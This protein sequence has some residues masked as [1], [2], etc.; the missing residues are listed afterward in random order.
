MPHFM[1]MT[2]TNEAEDALLTP[3]ETKLLVEGHSACERELR[4]SS[5]FVDSARL[6]PSA[7][8]RRVRVIEGRPRVEE[9]PFGESA[10][11]GYTVVAA[12][13]VDEAA[14]LAEH[15]PMSPSTTLDVRPVMKGQFDPEKA[16]RRGRVYAFAVLGNAPDEEGW[17]DVMDRIDAATG[18]TLPEGR[19]LGGVRLQAPG[20]GRRVTRAGG[21]RAIFDGPFL[22]S[23]EVIGGLFFLRMS[24]IEEAVGWVSGTTFV[25]H[26]A[27]EIRELWRS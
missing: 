18:G 15:C 4:K 1:V 11:G 14:A 26:G 17:I 22:E 9:G 21:R 3:S 12:E 25:R 6:R 2:I 16:D 19:A 20:R 24:T 7:E 13:S 27:I 10:L 23:K 8:G 5:A